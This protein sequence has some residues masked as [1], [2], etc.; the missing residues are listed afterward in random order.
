MPAQYVDLVQQNIG[1]LLFFATKAVFDALIL[2]SDVD[3]PGI[4]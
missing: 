3:Y 4:T 1:D 2:G